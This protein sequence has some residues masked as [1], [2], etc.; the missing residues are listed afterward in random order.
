[1]TTN[2][3]HLPNFARTSRWF[4]FPMRRK[5]PRSG[6]LRQIRVVIGSETTT[7][8]L[9][10]LEML[11]DRT[12][13]KQRMHELKPKADARIAE[14]ARLSA[15]A[16]ANRPVLSLDHIPIITVEDMNASMITESVS[17][18]ISFILGVFAEDSS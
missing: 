7:I 16:P 12:G 2:H 6:K 14:L 8:Q 10:S 17:S 15:P 11:V 18:Y 1:M 4:P 9:N 3:F 5:S 13:V